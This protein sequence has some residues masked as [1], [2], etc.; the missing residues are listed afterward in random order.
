MGKNFGQSIDFYL[1]LITGSIFLQNFR[2]DKALLLAATGSGDIDF[3]TAMEVNF[4][5]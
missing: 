5:K 2:Y 4:L 1:I 3:A